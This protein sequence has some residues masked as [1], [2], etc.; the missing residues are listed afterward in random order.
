MLLPRSA[1]VYLSKDIL[2]DDESH[3]LHICN[4]CFILLF[5]NC[6]HHASI[7]RINNLSHVSI[8]QY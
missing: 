1:F 2:E 6:W 3:I 8:N 4:A 5:K 7:F